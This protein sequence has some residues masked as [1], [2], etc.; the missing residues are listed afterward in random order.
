MATTTQLVT[1]EDLLEMG[2]DAPF[3]LWEGELVEVSPSGAKSS[4]IAFR[5]GGF[6]FN[7]AE[8]QNPGL[9]TNAEG[10]FVLSRNPNTVVAPDIGFVKGERLPAGLPSSFIEGCPDLAVEVIS[11]T[12]GPADIARKQALYARAGVPLVWWVDPEARTVTI[13]RPGQPP[14]V[15]DEKG[16]LDGGDVLPGF[17]LAVERIFRLV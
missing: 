6:L 5:I 8:T 7:Y 4:G 15:I 10:G 3:E 1:V 12:D 11:P 2:C 17:S 16:T 14:A 13:H 9:F